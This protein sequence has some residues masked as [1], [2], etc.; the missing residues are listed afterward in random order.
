ML[1]KKLNRF[2]TLRNQIL[3]VFL[4]V[5]TV[6]LLFVGVTTFHVVS[7]LLKNNAEEQIEQTVTQANG[8]LEALYKQLDGLTNQITTNM[9]VQQMLLKEVNGDYLGFRERQNLQQLV[10]SFQTYS[11]GIQSF[12][13]YTSN[14]KRVFPL[15]EIDLVNRLGIHWVKQAEEAKGKM[16]WIGRDPK[17]PHFFVVL[18]QIRLMDR[19]FS[20]GGYLLVRI[21]PEYFQFTDFI[22]SKTKKQG[23]MLVADRDLTPIFSNFVGDSKEILHAQQRTVQQNGEE[24]IVVKQTSPLTGWVL[25]IV[26]PVSALTDGVAIL[27]NTILFSGAIGFL[28]FFIFSLFLS[29]MVTQPILKL[30]KAMQRGKDGELRPSPPISSTVEINELNDTYNA[31]VENINHL[32]QVVYEKELV[33]SRAELK[34]LQAQINPHFLF[35]TLDA[36]YWS[37]VEKEEEELAQVVLNMSEL[38][39]YTVSNSK[40]DEWV[41]LYEE[42]EHI[43]RYMEIM[44]LRWGDRLL[45]NIVIPASCFDIRIPKLLIQPLVE[46]AVLHGIGNKTD[47]GIVWVTVEDCHE[48]SDIV[49]KVADDG[50]GMDEQTKEKV[51]ELLNNKE[52]SSAKGSGMALVNVNKRLQLYYGEERKLVI[53]SELGQG[54]VVLLKIPKSGEE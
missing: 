32:I 25:M 30:T 27:K 43:R 12:E 33:R 53:H 52:V 26:T 44:K 11:D 51:N 23:Y 35:N 16:V 21:N 4:F 13:L 45:W 20:P 37:L 42:I 36:L 10:N 1:T 31:L 39:R 41:T 48:S 47:L 2:N 34:A 15:D 49:I 54:T 46:N 50:Y 40:Q 6:V 18:R 24:Y 7:T 29:T 19:W 5:M 17:S 9:Y 38:F 22:T 14:Y 28:I 8:R 3:T